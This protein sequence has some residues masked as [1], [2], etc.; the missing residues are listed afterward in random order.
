MFT[1]ASSWLSFAG[2]RT[3]GN[4]CVLELLSVF[5]MGTQHF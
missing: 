2:W 1:T 5:T 4:D 3:L